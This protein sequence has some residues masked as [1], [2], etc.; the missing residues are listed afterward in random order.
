M[1]KN[2]LYQMDAV[3]FLT[4]FPRGSIDLIITD[5]PYAMNKANWDSFG[6]FTDFLKFTQK[7]LIQCER[8]LKEGGSIYVFNTPF[9]SAY[10]L[11]MLADLNL[12]YRNWITWNKRDGRSPQT[13]SFANEQETIL[14]FTKG[15]NH[16]FN[17][18]RVPYDYPRPTGRLKEAGNPEG[19]RYEINPE[20]KKCP[21]VWHYTSDRNIKNGLL[22][23]RDHLTPKPVAL[24]ERIILA[25]SNKGD[26]VVDC[27]L[28]SG[29]TAW[30]AESLD[31]A[32]I[33]CDID[34]SHAKKRMK[35]WNAKFL[36]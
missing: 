9:N 23:K 33:G 30:V 15:D 7:W 29:T 27:F 2:K 16:T 36:F 4:K 19:G 20:G 8:T 21:D 10:I 18:E 34:L 3:D 1:E 14:F 12:N 22:K 28:G 17:I 11:Q 5:P 13:R 6:S 24:I 26:L 31:R 35:N 25:S 32:F